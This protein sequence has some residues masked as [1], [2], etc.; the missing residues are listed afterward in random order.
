MRLYRVA[1]APPGSRPIVLRGL[2]CHLDRLARLLDTVAQTAIGQ[3]TLRAIASTPHTLTIE[4]SE[5][6]LFTSG[7]S[8]TI[9]TRNTL[10]GV[11][12]NVT[13]QLDLRVP[14]TGSHR[15]SARGSGYVDF[16]TDVI[17]AHELSHARRD[18]QGGALHVFDREQDAIIDENVYRQQI[19]ALRGEP[20]AL[21]D[22]RGHDDDHQVWFP[23]DGAPLCPCSAH[24]Q[25]A[26]G[27]TTP[28]G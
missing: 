6:A 8:F 16:P 10:N 24:R 12:T 15:V 13:I 18:M 2:P 3:E 5:S 25:A 27:D 4:H 23:S 28:P 26:R 19:A 21:R 14:D 7:K 17:M 1:G 11:G 20:V 22:E 9:A